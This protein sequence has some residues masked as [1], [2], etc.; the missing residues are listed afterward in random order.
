MVF[1]G[2]D[3]PFSVVAAMDVRGYQLEFRVLL[4]EV[5][6]QGLAAFIVEGVQ[7]QLAAVANKFVVDMFVGFENGGTPTVGDSPNVDRVAV[8]VVEEKDVVVAGAG[9][10]NK[11]AGE[12]GERLARAGVPDGRV[13]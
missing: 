1:E 6:F 4:M 12:V 8:V 13:A 7:E 10:D 5:I 11:A 2:A 9:W 3:G